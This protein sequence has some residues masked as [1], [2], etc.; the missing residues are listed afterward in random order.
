[1][2]GASPTLLACLL[3]RSRGKKEKSSQPSEPCQDEN[4]E[5]E[6]SSQTKM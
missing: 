4:E 5:A 2:D 1:M 3:P 6:R